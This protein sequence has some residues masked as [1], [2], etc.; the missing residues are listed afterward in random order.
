MRFDRTVYAIA[1]IVV[2]MGAIFALMLGGPGE[3]ST[4]AKLGRVAAVKK[5]AA[6]QLRDPSS[7]QFR[8]IANDGLFVCGEI[9]GK[10]GY[11][12]YAGFTRFYGDQTMVS[13]DP[14]NHEK[15]A[16]DIPSDSEV[17]DRSWKAFCS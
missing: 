8:N 10:N 15:L 6:S 5:L 11:G 13:I 2:A 9:N 12:A 7:A 17:F 3:V 1:A 4:F 16:P 14:D